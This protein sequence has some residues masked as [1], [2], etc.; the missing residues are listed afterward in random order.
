MLIC[1]KF[2]FMFLDT[3][4]KVVVNNICAVVVVF[5][6]VFY[7]FVGLDGWCCW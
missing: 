3:S 1:F 2:I 4:L 5:M 6:V 7:M